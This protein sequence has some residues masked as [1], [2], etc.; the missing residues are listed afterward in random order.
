MWLQFSLNQA[1][2]TASLIVCSVSPQFSATVPGFHFKI[3]DFGFH[4]ALRFATEH[5]LLQIYAIATPV[6][7]ILLYNPIQHETYKR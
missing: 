5:L 3:Q 4:C 1:G 6:P 7:H 2:L